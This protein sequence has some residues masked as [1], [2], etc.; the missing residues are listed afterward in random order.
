M[1]KGPSRGA[2]ASTVAGTFLGRWGGIQGA[3]RLRRR[4]RLM[5]T[6]AGTMVTT[7]A[8]TQNVTKVVY[9]IIFAVLH[10]GTW[11]VV[12]PVFEGKTCKALPS[13][14]EFLVIFAFVNILM[15][16]I[17]VYNNWK[18][19]NKG[20]DPKMDCHVIPEEGELYEGH[21]TLANVYMVCRGASRAT[22]L[23]G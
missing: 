1:G 12:E 4:R 16:P 10:L 15:L 7:A 2:E 5:N 22:R 8:G 19:I 20:L 3:A 21:K 18:R 11:L 13:A 14:V 23:T 6:R 9:M 17:E